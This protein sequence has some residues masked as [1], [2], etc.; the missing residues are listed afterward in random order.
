MR[1]CA[2]CRG[3]DCG[4][5]YGE[6]VEDPEAYAAYLEEMEENDRQR[7]EEWRHQSEVDWRRCGDGEVKGDSRRRWWK[8]R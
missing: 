1:V 6:V 3:W 4:G 5:C 8:W 2:E 7:L